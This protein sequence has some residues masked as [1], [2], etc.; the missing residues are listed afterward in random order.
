MVTMVVR[1]IQAN[2]EVIQH[3]DNQQRLIGP[4]TK[5]LKKQHT[6]TTYS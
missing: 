1:V 4:N 5:P 2:E 6:P 3:N